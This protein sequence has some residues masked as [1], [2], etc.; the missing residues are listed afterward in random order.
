MHQMVFQEENKLLSKAKFFMVKSILK[1]PCKVWL[2]AM[3]IIWV[4]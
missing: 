3:V 2:E 1:M 4:D